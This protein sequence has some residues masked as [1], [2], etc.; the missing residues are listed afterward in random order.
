MDEATDEAA[1]VLA[2]IERIQ[3][4]DREQAPVSSL[5]GELRELVAEAEAWV[6]VEGD[7][8]AV[9]AAA[10][11]AESVGRVEEVVLEPAGA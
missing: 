10:Q 2:R 9:A 11:L 1:R 6:R 3:A 5:L 7:D 8:R 4:L